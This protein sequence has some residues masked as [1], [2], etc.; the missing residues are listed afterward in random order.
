[1]QQLNTLISQVNHH[2]FLHTATQRSG[3]KHFQHQLGR[4]ADCLLSQLDVSTFVLL[5]VCLYHLLQPLSHIITKNGG[6][7]DVPWWRHFLCR[8]PWHS[9][10]YSIV[11]PRSRYPAWQSPTDELKSHGICV[12][13]Y[14]DSSPGIQFR[15]TKSILYNGGDSIF[16][17][18]DDNESSPL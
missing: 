17:T 8:R 13:S 6:R 16:G 12:I 14:N 18:V 1:M 4:S 9:T 3:K 2:L 15:I 10:L 5:L 7:A 11:L